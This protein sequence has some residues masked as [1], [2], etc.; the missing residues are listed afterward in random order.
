MMYRRF[1]SLIL[2]TVIVSLWLMF[3]VLKPIYGQS[4][5]QTIDATVQISVCGNSTVEGGEDCEGNDLS[6]NTCRTLGYSS[7]S[8][9]CDISC[10]FDTFSCLTAS[11]DSD[12]SDSDESDGD[13]SSSSSS[14]SNQV[15]SPTTVNNVSTPL[16]EE[17][18]LPAFLSRFNNGRTG[19][20]S[21]DQL[22]IVVKTW[23]DEWRNAVVNNEGHPFEASSCDL[24]GDNECNA[25]D[26]SV[27]LYYIEQ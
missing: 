13:S 21:V 18:T 22:Y 27:L 17:F 15:S 25:K 1:R 24:D 7:G 14:S 11:S 9:S 26:F 4:S 12:D 10:S 16:S 8:L 19:K 2:T 6:S 23:V 20:I 5:M 3:V